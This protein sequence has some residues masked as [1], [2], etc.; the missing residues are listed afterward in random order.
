MNVGN[1]LHLDVHH[2]VQA[3]DIKDRTP[4][5]RW[6]KLSFP[7]TVRES[8]EMAEFLQSLN[9]ECSAD[10]TKKVKSVG[11]D[12]LPS[13]FRSFSEEAL[14]SPLSSPPRSRDDKLKAGDRKKGGD[15]ESK[16]EGKGDA[17]ARRSLHKARTKARRREREAGEG[18]SNET[19]VSLSLGENDREED[20]DAVPLLAG[21]ASDE[22]LQCV[23]Q[24]RSRLPRIESGD[25]GS[26]SESRPDT[27][28]RCS[29]SV[30]SNLVL[31]NSEEHR[32]GSRAA[33]A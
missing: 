20:D 1:R 27:K 13:R 16:G 3:V 15:G 28:L 30:S 23:D 29:S 10:I 8:P 11:D 18:N 14:T 17:K 26:G 19:A 2:P 24:H 6:A 7:E 9:E 12:A 22:V 21:G 5:H 32:D 33:G 25:S 4:L 31:C